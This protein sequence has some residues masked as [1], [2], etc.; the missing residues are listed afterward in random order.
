M[1]DKEAVILTIKDIFYFFISYSMRCIYAYVFV[2]FCGAKILNLFGIDMER[3]Y[4][5]SFMIV[6][7]FIVLFLSIYVLYD[8]NLEKLKKERWLKENGYK[9]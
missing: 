2:I 6:S 3:A 5:L 4:A 7:I 1:L 8:N 9:D